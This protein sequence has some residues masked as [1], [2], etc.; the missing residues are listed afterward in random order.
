MK[1]HI[2]CLVV[3]TALA[4]ALP[5]SAVT[6]WVYTEQSPIQDNW[7]IEGEAHELGINFPAGELISAVDVPWGGH[8]PCPTDYQGRGAVQV[9]IVNLTGRVW[10]SLYYVADPETSLSNW[11]EM[12]GQLGSNPWLAFRIDAVGVNTPLVFESMTPDGVF[13]LNEIW[14]FVI[15]EYQGLGPA[16]ALD[17]IGVIAGASAGFPPSTGSIIAVPEPAAMAPVMLLGALGAVVWARRRT[18]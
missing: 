6:V 18:S 11:D 2:V 14:Q 3:F 4:L 17:S 8:I 7:F 12:V 10:P 15:Q 9:E 13:E 5:L 1:K 16:S